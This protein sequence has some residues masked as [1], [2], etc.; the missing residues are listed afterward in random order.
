MDFDSVLM[1]ASFAGFAM[2]PFWGKWWST[3]VLRGRKPNLARVCAIALLSLATLCIFH[4]GPW[5]VMSAR[6]GLLQENLSRPD[7]PIAAMI[8]FGPGI[9]IQAF[10]AIYFARQQPSAS[11]PQQNTTRN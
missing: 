9:L 4:V 7:A 3:F 11:V 10:F 5:L 8:V 2:A 1:F 6:H